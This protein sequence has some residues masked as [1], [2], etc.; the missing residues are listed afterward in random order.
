MGLTGKAKKEYQK[1]YMRRKRS[2]K[3][4]TE[5]DG[6][7]KQGLTP[8]GTPAIL[9]YPERYSYSKDWYK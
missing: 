5:D 6:S 8:D 4:L 1:E 7:N 9:S 2:N 3:G